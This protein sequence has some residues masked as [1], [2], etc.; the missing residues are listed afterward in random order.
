MLV[1]HALSIPFELVYPDAPAWPIR[2]V[3]IAINTVQYPLPSPKRCLA[4]GRAVA[5][6]L[7][8][9]T[10]RTGSGGGH[11]RPFAPARR[12]ARRVHEPDYDRFCLDPPRGRSRCADAPFGRGRGRTGGTQ[13]VEILNWIA[14]RGRWATVR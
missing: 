7:R 14:A 8:S 2:L 12:P 1:D 6:A 10:G 5:K 9:W 3:P 13:G 4:L 11:G